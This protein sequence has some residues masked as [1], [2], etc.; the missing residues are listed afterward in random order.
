MKRWLAV[1]LLV[2]CPWAL[3][4]EVLVIAFD[5]M[6]DPIKLPKDTNLGEATG[7]AVN[8]KALSVLGESGKQPRPFGWI[9]EIAC[10]SP[11]VVYVAEL[12][13]WRIQKLMLH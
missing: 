3:A 13:N 6:P 9:H 11:N 12:L 2:S 8:S 5:S 1:G 7:V 4:Q 10:P